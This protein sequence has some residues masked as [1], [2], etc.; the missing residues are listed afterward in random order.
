M[1]VGDFD[2]VSVMSAPHETDPVLIV[3]PDAVMPLPVAVQFFQPVAWWEPQVSQFNR[4]IE[5]GELSPGHASGRRAPSL[6][7]S[8]DFR[9]LLVG[10]T[11]D[12]SPILTVHVNNVNRY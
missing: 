5:D 1:I 4:A 11:L 2:V 8:P 6:A 12:H 3:D 7:R 9:R 10:E